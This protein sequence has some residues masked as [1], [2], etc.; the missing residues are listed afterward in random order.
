MAVFVTNPA[1][2]SNG[3]VNILIAKHLGVNIR[4]EAGRKA[5][6][7]FKRTAA[8]KAWLSKSAKA[9]T[10]ERA[11]KKK[12]TAASK[13]PAAKKARAAF[14]ARVR[15]KKAGKAPA[16]KAGR[17][18]STA[19]ATTGAGGTRIHKT[20]SGKLM[21]FVGGKPTGRLKYEA[22]VGKAGKAPAAKASA[23]K[24]KGRG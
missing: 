14:L 19:V 11:A 4:T 13:T 15:A 20:S 10:S 3:A 21:Y 18:A 9:I 1:S 5:V 7:A 8:Y 23:S 2:R 22:A 16:R 17:K 24:A 12:R 6:A